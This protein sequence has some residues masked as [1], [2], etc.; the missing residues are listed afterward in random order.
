MPF[1][2]RPSER[3]VF[4]APVAIATET[5]LREWVDRVIADAGT[6]PRKSATGA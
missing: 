5:A 1:A 3:V 4:V 2:R 6:R